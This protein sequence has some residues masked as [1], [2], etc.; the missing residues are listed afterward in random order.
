MRKIKEV[1][2]LKWERGLSNRQIGGLRRQP[3]HGKRVPSAFSR[4]GSELAITGGSG[5]GSPRTT[6]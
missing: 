3:P 4:S 6:L 5:G 2:R 1:L